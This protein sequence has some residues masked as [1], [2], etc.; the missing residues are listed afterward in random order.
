MERSP[1]WETDNRL[2]IQEFSS[3]LEPDLI[4]LEL[5]ILIIFGEE[6]ESLSYSEDMWCVM[7]KVGYTSRPIFCH[8]S[9]SLW[10]KSPLSGEIRLFF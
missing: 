8:E 4:L 7:S 5:V 10:N 6:D 3:L 9:D 1:S 2:F